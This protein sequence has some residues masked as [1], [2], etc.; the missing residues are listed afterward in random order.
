MS[1]NYGFNFRRHTHHVESLSDP[2]SG[3]IIFKSFTCPKENAKKHIGNHWNIIFQI[4]SPPPKKKKTTK[5]NNSILM[6]FWSSKNPEINR[7]FYPVSQ[8]FAGPS[9][10]CWVES[11]AVNRWQLRF[12]R[13]LPNNPLHC[14][15]PRH[16]NTLP[17]FEVLLVSWLGSDGDGGRG[18]KFS[19]NSL[20]VRKCSN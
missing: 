12:P 5:Q 16:G 18:Q 10:H 8:G 17:G 4:P 7:C 1:H 6:H 13:L 2:F 20:K 11:H 15:Q 3:A 14:M 19:P 9:H